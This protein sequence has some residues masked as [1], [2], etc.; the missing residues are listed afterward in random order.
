[1]QV[2]SYLYFPP[3]NYARIPILLQLVFRETRFARRVAHNE[4]KIRLHSKDF[5]RQRHKAV[6]LQLFIARPPCGN[7]AG[8]GWMNE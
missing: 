1:M 2:P 8:G 3:I 6:Q 4:A 5:L 7:E